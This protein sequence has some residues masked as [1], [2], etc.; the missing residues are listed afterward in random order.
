MI[1]AIVTVV[2]LVMSVEPT[3]VHVGRRSWRAPVGT[4]SHF[5]MIS[6]RP[7]SSF[8]KVRKNIM[9]QVS[10]SSPEDDK[11]PDQ[12]FF[13][14]APTIFKPYV[15]SSCKGTM[16]GYRRTTRKEL[17][18]GLVWSFEQSMELGSL[19]V[20]IRSIAVGYFLPPL[21]TTSSSSSSI[22]KRK[23]VGA[24]SPFP[25]TGLIVTDTVYSVPRDPPEVVSEALLLDVA[26]DDPTKPVEDSPVIRQQAWAKM[27]L[28][29]A[30]FIPA[31]QR[32][33]EKLVFEKAAPTV[34]EWVEEV[35]K[36]PFTQ[37]FPAHYQAPVQAGPREL[38]KAFGFAYPNVEARALP[39]EDM[40]TLN[41]LGEV[42]QSV[43]KRDDE[44]YGK[45]FDKFFKNLF[46]TKP[47]WLKDKGG[48][49][50][51]N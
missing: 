3:H 38:R 35:A 16:T 45:L 24:R 11:N 21:H 43:G 28:L 39:H 29:V 34:R 7:Q 44:L 47:G 41:D 37:I 1:R 18:E 49:D 32:I 12:K 36:W 4:K 17:V 10:L 22:I 13:L 2:I 9:M 20:N 23:V 50:G 14:P 27:A 5:P 48:E 6:M 30:F 8:R 19:A 46:V 26:P 33:V 51:R 31:R 40:K 42:I 25:D 15:G